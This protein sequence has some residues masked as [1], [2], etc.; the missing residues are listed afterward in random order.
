MAFS[1]NIQKER[2]IRLYGTNQPAR[3]AFSGPPIITIR[4]DGYYELPLTATV[5]DSNGVGVPGVD[6]KM[7]LI[8]AEEGGEI[9]GMVMQP[10]RTDENGKATA[11]YNP[12]GHAGEVIIRC[13]LESYIPESG[14]LMQDVRIHIRLLSEHVQN[15]PR[16]IRPGIWTKNLPV[17]ILF[18]ILFS[19]V[20]CQRKILLI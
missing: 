12:L 4:P 10:E 7:S 15:T 20:C 3:L 17:E 11:V 1:G 8:P 14:I 18:F 16:N 2:T 5:T 6:L 9:F 19:Y 13:V